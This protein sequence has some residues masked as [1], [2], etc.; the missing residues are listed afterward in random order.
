MI[1]EYVSMFKV[2]VLIYKDVW[3]CITFDI[4]YKYSETNFEVTPM[5]PETLR[6]VAI[7]MV[8]IAKVESEIVLSAID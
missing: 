4:C 3:L 5:I 7:E 2:V 8:L 6:G 1:S